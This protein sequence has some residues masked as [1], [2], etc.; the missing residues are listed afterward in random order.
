MN[1]ILYPALICLMLWPSPPLFCQKARDLRP[2]IVHERI[3][4]SQDP[5]ET[6][7]IFLPEGY[8]HEKKWPLLLCFDPGGNPLTPLNLLALSAD[9]S[10]F[11]LVSPYRVKNGPLQPS[12]K[13]LHAVWQEMTA[14]FP[15]DRQR[16]YA[17][18]FSGGAHMASL[19]SRLT[20]QP[21][22]GIL[23]CGAVLS[24]DVSADEIHN[25]LFFGIIGLRDFN[26]RE[27]RQLKQTLSSRTR[28]SR[29]LTLHLNHSWPPEPQCR[30]ALEWFDLMAMKEG[31]KPRNRNRIEM[32]L[33][34]ERARVGE[35]EKKGELYF[36]AQETDDLLH[37]FS[38]LLEASR[39]E[40]LKQKSIE[41][42]SSRAHAQF[43]KAEQARIRR[44]EIIHGKAAAAFALFHRGIPQGSRASQIITGLG[45]KGLIREASRTENS[46][47]ADMISRV[48]SSI[49]GEATR[50]MMICL[51]N[52]RLSPAAYF[53]ET[54]ARASE[55]TQGYPVARY[56]Q[57]VI[58]ARQNKGKQALK[59]LKDAVE[60]GFSRPLLLLQDADL[61]SLRKLPEF[62]AILQKAQEQAKEKG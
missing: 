55:G 43:E 42:K 47:D 41:L 36:A 8:N 62:R 27:M 1:K 46:Y 24:P 32:L 29:L 56:N 18:G 30:R 26:Y 7:A 9:E 5:G 15:I 53:A 35:R 28:P 48:L 13:A 16:V 58:L 54:A 2:G 21:L 34:K 10:G 40:P 57:A 51:E 6:Y 17:G 38:G 49:A 50:Q 45:L 25:T 31:L 61:D 33:Q 14:E 19:F 3:P 60:N 44:E 52:Q 59:V 11:I 4:C 37:T 23:C 12:L 22:Q 20:G 39:L